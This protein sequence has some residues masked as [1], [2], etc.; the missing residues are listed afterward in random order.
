MVV[1]QMT[2]LPQTRESSIGVQNLLHEW[3][4]RNSIERSDVTALSRGMELAAT[5]QS[6]VVCLSRQD[7]HHLVSG[8]GLSDPLSG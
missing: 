2:D 5:L 3:K 8:T 6:Q 1:L 7:L 4:L